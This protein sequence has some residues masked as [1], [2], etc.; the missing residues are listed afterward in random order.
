MRAV[1]RLTVTLAV[2]VVAVAFSGLAIGYRFGSEATNNYRLQQHTVLRN[3]IAEFS[4]ARAA[5]AR[6]IHA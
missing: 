2:L 6:S 1:S 3:T 4:A 5:K